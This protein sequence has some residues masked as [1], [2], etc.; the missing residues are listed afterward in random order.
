[1]HELFPLLSIKRRNKLPPQRTE[2]R[3]FDDSGDL[4]HLQQ[5][6][7]QSAAIPNPAT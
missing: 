3:L 2:I 5:T 4:E 1:M 6:N 7:L